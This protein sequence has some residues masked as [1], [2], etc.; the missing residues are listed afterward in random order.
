ML[1]CLKRILSRFYLIDSC[2][3]TNY[4][5]KTDKEGHLID[6]RLLGSID[7]KALLAQPL[8]DWI[9]YNIYILVVFVLHQSFLG[10]AFIY[11]K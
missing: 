2:F 11:F 4:S 9:D 10:M 1:M 3:H 8:E 6:I 7:V 5:H